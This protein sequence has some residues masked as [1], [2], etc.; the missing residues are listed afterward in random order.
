VRNATINSSPYLKNSILDYKM[1]ENKKTYWKGL[2]QL[3]NDPEFVKTPIRNF[4]ELPSS[5]SEDGSSSEET[6]LK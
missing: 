4:V 5:L 6:S 2:E 3:N 1:K